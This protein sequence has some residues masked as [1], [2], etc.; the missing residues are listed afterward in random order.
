MQ[1]DKDI[2]PPSE[3]R[4]RPAKYPFATMEVGD[5]FLSPEPVARMSPAASYAGKRG[6]MR[7]TVRAEGAGA[8]V[9]RIA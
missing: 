3:T 4:G 6:G 7:F 9:W 1:I 5:S 8:R 2:P